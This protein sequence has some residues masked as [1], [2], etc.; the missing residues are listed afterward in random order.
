LQELTSEDKKYAAKNLNESDENRENAIAEIRGWIKDELRIRI[1]NFFILRFLRVC[2]FNLEKTKIRMRNYYKQ[3]SDLPEW[4]MNKDPFQ[5]ELQ[6]LLDM[7]LFLPL[8]KLDSQGKLN[9]II[10]GTRYNPTKHKLSDFIKIGIMMV[11]LAMK[12]NGDAIA[13]VHGCAVFIDVVNPTIRYIAHFPPHTLM[14][15]IHG[16]QSCYPLRVQSINFI[17]APRIADGIVRIMKSFMTEKMKNR[18][19]IYSHMSQSCFKDVPADIL[20]IEYGGTDGTIQE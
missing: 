6:K 19:Y 13:S 4:Y 12:N 18:F 7:G 15:V 1:D 17:N 9:F 8:R 3:R 5:P 14:N 11:E 16:W 10:R 20:P 2:K